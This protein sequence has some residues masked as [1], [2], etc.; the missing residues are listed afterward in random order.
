MPEASSSVAKAALRTGT[1]ATGDEPIVPE[2]SSSVAKAALRTGTEAAGDEPMEPEAS[3]SAAR[4]ATARAAAVMV[5]AAIAMV[6]SEPESFE[7][8]PSIP[9]RQ[10]E[11]HSQPCSSGPMQCGPHDFQ[12]WQRMQTKI[13]APRNAKNRTVPEIAGSQHGIW[14]KG[15]AP[16]RTGDQSQCL[17]PSLEASAAG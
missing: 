13:E 10:Y 12:S 6:E 16:A 5:H 11:S 15:T 4:M 2:A 17:L 14:A 1:E 7:P 8:L 9:A 3:S